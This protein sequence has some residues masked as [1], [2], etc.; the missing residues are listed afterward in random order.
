MKT[1][2]PRN[3]IERAE[4]MSVGVRFFEGFPNILNK[5]IFITVYFWFMTY[6]HQLTIHR[7]WNTNKFMCEFTYEVF[8]EIKKLP[9]LQ[10]LEKNESFWN[11]FGNQVSG[12]LI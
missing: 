2:P 11:W 9:S 7:K 3:R 12:V 10:I 8:H 4:S 5:M 6:I 1:S